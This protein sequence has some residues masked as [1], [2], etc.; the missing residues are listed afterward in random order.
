MTFAASAAGT[1]LG[2]VFGAP[3]VPGT[4]VSETIVPTTEVGAATQL[5]GAV[6]P[7]GF[8]DPSGP[9]YGIMQD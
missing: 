8:D 7:G 3:K 6:A 4:G 9:G 1:V 5:V 2:Q